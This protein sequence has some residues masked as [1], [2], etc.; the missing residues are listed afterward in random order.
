MDLGDIELKLNSNLLSGSKHIIP[1]N[2]ELISNN[3]EL[4]TQ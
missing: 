4:L 1:W 2:N 3:N